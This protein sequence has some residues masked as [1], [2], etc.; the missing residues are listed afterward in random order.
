M[1]ADGDAVSTPT[2]REDTP[3]TDEPVHEINVGKHEGYLLR[4]SEACEKAKLIIIASSFTPIVMD[5]SDQCFGVVHGERI[6]FRAVRLAETG[7]S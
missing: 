6:D 4:R 2:T 3:D 5:S 7:A 1:L